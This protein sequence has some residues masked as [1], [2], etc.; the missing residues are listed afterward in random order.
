[1]P[2]GDGR[3]TIEGALDS[4]GRRIT[5]FGTAAR[6]T[7][8]LLYHRRGLARQLQDASGERCYTRS[9]LQRLV[10]RLAR[11]DHALTFTTGK[12]AGELTGA[13]GQR[14]QDGCAIV[15]D[16]YPAPDGHGVV[17]AIHG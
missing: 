5:V 12:V 14:L 4:E 7:M 3:R 15:S 2:G 13:V 11:T 1:M 6:S 9:A 16:V 10:R 17:V 8:D